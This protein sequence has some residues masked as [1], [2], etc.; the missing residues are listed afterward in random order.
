MGHLPYKA[1]EDGAD[2]EKKWDTQEPETRGK[3]FQKH[4]D[5]CHPETHGANFPTWVLSM[6]KAKTISKN[7]LSLGWPYLKFS[8]LGW[9]SLE[10]ISWVTKAHVFMRVF[11][12]ILR[13]P[14]TISRGK[15]ITIFNKLSPWY[16][17][18]HKPK[19][20][21][22]ITEYWYWKAPV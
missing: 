8:Q 4:K 5:R 6:V 16:K 3:L 14:G 20:P 13:G 1:Q 9:M 2:Q 19:C 17:R 12:R 11:P 7:T 10:R 21:R 15:H 22:K 18:W